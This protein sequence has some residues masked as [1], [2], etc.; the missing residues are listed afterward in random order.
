MIAATYVINLAESRDRWRHMSRVLQDMGVPRPQRFDA[1]DG[2]SLD[3]AALQATGELAAD[4]SGFDRKCVNG[5]IACALSHRG[6][7]A[8]IVQQ[9]VPAALVLEDDIQLNGAA[10]HWPRRFKRAFADLPSDWELWYLYRCFDIEHRAIRVTRRTVVP[11]SPQGGAAYAVTLSG[12]EKLLQAMTPVCSAVDR[13]YADLVTRRAVTAYAASPLLIIPGEHPSI[14]N[15]GNI[16][17]EW[18]NEGIN[19]P[20]EYWPKRYFGYL[21]ETAP[22]GL[23][24]WKQDVANFYED[25]IFRLR[26]MTGLA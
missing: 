4:L 17:K 22:P 11:W 24:Y 23:F 5:E 21:G 2:T 14:I 8:N 18:V 20:P 19:R 7:L 3:Y 10:W 26:K 25:V 16:A 1:I 6:V 9:R 13:I 15:R 12:A